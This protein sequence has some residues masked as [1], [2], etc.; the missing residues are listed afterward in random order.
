MNAPSTMPRKSP[1]ERTKWQWDYRHNKSDEWKREYT[2]RGTLR[3]R[4]H[5]QRKRE[6]LA[7]QQEAAAAVEN[8]D[9]LTVR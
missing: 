5:R 6:A 2:A 4:E 1:K 9:I 3:R 8:D 7:A